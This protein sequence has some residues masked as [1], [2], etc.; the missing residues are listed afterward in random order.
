MCCAGI[1]RS[2]RLLYKEGSRN[3]IS[4][5]KRR[6]LVWSHRTWRGVGML[7]RKDGAIGTP[8]A[9]VVGRT[10]VPKSRRTPKS[11]APKS[12]TPKLKSRALLNVGRPRESRAWRRCPSPGRPSRRR[13]GHPSRGRPSRDAQVEDAQVEDAQVEG[14][15]YEMSPRGAK[16]H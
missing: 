3:F 5:A 1:S 14:E 7:H 16:F 4:G 11:R 2:A 8:I 6:P 9:L 10:R 15:I 13:G 12:R